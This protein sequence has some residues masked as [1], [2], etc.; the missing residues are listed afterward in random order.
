MAEELESL[1]SILGE[2]ASGKGEPA[3]AEPAPPAV[4]PKAEAPAAI[5]PKA[6][7]VKEPV[8]DESGRFAPKTE[9][10]PK[11]PEPVKEPTRADIAAIIDERR[12]RQ[13]LERQVQELQAGKQK[14]DFWENPEAALEARVNEVVNPLQSQN[15][16]LQ[17]DIARLKYTDFDEVMMG[18]LEAAQ[19]DPVLKAQADNSPDPLNFIYREG[20]R[21]K[22]LGPYGGDLAKR[23]EAKFGELKAEGAKKDEL[24]KAL[25]TELE[26]LKKSQAELAAV[27][28]S[29]NAEQSGT[30]KVSDVDDDDLKK[31]VRFK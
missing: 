18:F 17:V 26:T 24:I 9:V 11:P 3:K 7:E 13:A 12:K 1:S 2:S 6:A 15:L 27:P 30:P 23:D 22:E 20:K 29:L 5:E 14:P 8:R 25:Q 21:L 4:A 19:K 31:I 10:Q 16:Q 28:R